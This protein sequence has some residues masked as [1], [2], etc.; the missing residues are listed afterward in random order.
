MILPPVDVY[1]IP[2][3]RISSNGSVFVGYPWDCWRSR[4][5]ASITM[6]AYRHYL[7]LNGSESLSCG[8]WRHQCLGNLRLCP[9]VSKNSSFYPFFIGLPIDLALEGC[10]EEAVCDNCSFHMER[11]IELVQLCDL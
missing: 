5:S 4:G 1:Y 2:F 8:Y 9:K 3:N 11:W 6:D 7:Y 10:I